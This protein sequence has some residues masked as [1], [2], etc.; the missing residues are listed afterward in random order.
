VILRL[1][2]EFIE[3]WCFY[4]LYSF[5]NP[6]SVFDTYKK[7]LKIIRKERQEVIIKKGIR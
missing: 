3:N 4:Y 6:P 7:N 1:G 2:G 5:I